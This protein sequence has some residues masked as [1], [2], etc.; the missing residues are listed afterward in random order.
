MQVYHLAL[1]PVE[2]G[3]LPKFN[4]ITDPKEADCILVTGGD[5]AILHSLG[6]LIKHGITD[7]PILGFNTGHVGF[8]SNDLTQEQLLEIIGCDYVDPNFVEERCLLQVIMNN[9]AS[10]YAL[11][12][13]VFQTLKYG[14]LFELDAIIDGRSVV[15]YKGDGL[16]VSTATG[17]TAYNLS[18]GGPIVAPTLDIITV[19][20][21]CPFTMAARSIVLSGNSI[22]DVFPKEPC[23]L[24]CDGI[25]T[26]LECTAKIRKAPFTLKLVK[27]TKF[28]DAIK[29]K[30]GWN[31][32]IK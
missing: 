9:G 8:L 18:A 24:S 30:L 29:Y 26:T 19:T 22:I 6:F 27:Y 7:T 32:N 20:P 31:Q 17:S 28:Y 2:R 23:A 12:D 25:I 5:G 13:C 10:V 11:N 1:R 3:V 21:I 16:I 14:K 4:F 15:N